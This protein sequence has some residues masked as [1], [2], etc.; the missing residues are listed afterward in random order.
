[1]LFVCLGNSCRSPMAEA[2]ARHL[3]ADVMEPSSAGISPLG[4][5]A[6]ETRK[7]LAERGVSAAGLVS[8][9]LVKQILNSTDLIVNMS[10]IPS[11]SIFQSRRAI[12]WDVQDPYGEDLEL[13][14]QIC[15]DIEKRVAALAK[16]LRVELKSSAVNA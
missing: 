6:E 4:H 15:D 9:G 10:G 5:V 7:V 14:R 8:K 2:L 11:E 3:A 12:D 1:M 16:D 13:Y